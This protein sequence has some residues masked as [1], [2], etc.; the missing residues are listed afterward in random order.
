MVLGGVG[1]QIKWMHDRQEAL[2][3]LM[4]LHSRQL[5]A[6]GGS[7]LPSKKGTYVSH[8][9]IKAP[10]SLGV[11]GELGVER[12]EVD[13]AWL[14]PDAPYTLAEFKS[15]FPEAEVTATP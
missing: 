14:I 13:Q 7:L 1:V 9:E 11:F 2:Q 4:P 12:I 10:W 5:A 6:K 15:L 8:S 3:W